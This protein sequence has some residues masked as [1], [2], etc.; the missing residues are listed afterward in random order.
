MKRF[1]LDDSLK[2]VVEES[3]ENF[4]DEE[5]EVI[6]NNDFLNKINLLIDEDKINPNI[7]FKSVN[8]MILSNECISKDVIN[9]DLNNNYDTYNRHWYLL[10]KEQFDE[11]IKYKIKTI[12]IPLINKI[13]IRYII[14]INNINIDKINEF[15]S[16]NFLNELSKDEIIKKKQIKRKKIDLIL[17]IIFSITKVSIIYII[18]IIIYK[19]IRTLQI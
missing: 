16:E 12:E 18:V 13:A 9:C 10:S 5:I 19:Y 1:E 6:Y 3:A 2:E 17:G 7:K 8:N 14:E 4:L 15:I 11:S